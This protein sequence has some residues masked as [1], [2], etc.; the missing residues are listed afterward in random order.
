MLL[1]MTGYGDAQRKLDGK[2]A[3]V[4]V[5]TINGRY[6]KLSVK[7]FEGYNSLEPRDRARRAATDSSRLGAGGDTARRPAANRPTTGINRPLLESYRRQL[8]D[9]FHE[10]EASTI[11]CRTAALFALPGVVADQLL[12][13]AE[14]SEDWPLIE[15]TL[16]AACRIWPSMPSRRE[17]RWPPTWPRTADRSA[18]SLRKSKP[19]RR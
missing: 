14:L 7:C 9:L 15:E 19:A 5:R 13:P 11:R 18:A 3:W 10:L 8:L 6:F 2:S 12:S 16:E 17:N 1:S 4:E